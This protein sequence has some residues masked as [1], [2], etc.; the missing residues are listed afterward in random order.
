LVEALPR[1]AR[2]VVVATPVER[3]GAAV[4]LVIACKLP[5]GLLETAPVVAHAAFPPGAIRGQVVL[6]R[7][8]ALVIRFAQVVDAPVRFLD[9]CIHLRGGAPPIS[10]RRNK[11]RV[12]CHPALGKNCHTLSVVAVGAAQPQ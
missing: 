1:R 12:G 11:S 7:V 4:S 10:R 8:A 3:R 2:G 6:E 5:L 9:A